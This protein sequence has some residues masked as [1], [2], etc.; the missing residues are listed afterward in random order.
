MSDFY[1]IYLIRNGSLMVRL[2]KK[3]FL[4]HYFSI[5]HFLSKQELTHVH[6]Q[7]HL[8]L[9]VPTCTHHRATK[10]R[11]AWCRLSYLSQHR[12]VDLQKEKAKIHLKMTISLCHYLQNIF[13]LKEKSM[14]DSGMTIR[15]QL[16]SQL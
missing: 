4:T 8:H 2:K 16:A 1:Q 9:L 15:L 14:L 6:N 13:L 11:A 3:S 5:R 7:L 10:S 12:H